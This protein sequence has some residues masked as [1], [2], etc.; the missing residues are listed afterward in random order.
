TSDT[1]GYANTV[2]VVAP[3]PIQPAV[4]SVRVSESVDTP[5]SEGDSQSDTFESPVSDCP[6]ATAVTRARI[7]ILELLAGDTEMTARQ[8]RGG[9]ISA[10]TRGGVGAALESL[11]TSGEI[12]ARQDGQK[13]L[14]RLAGTPIPQ[15]DTAS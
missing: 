13:T 14:Y 4:R 3:S 11:M 5:S 9:R 8:M 1:H 10:N 15:E 7:K 12:A 6:N 2:E